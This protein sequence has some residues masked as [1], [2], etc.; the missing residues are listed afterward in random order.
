MNAIEA[1]YKIRDIL[2][3][4]IIENIKIPLIIIG[5]ILLIVIFFCI[6]KSK[7]KKSKKIKIK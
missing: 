1:V 6:I 2:L 3:N 7:K 5:I 4:G